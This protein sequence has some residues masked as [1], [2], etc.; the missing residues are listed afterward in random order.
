MKP[1]SIILDLLR[2]Y[3]SRGT[4]VQKIMAT[5]SM[6]GF[7][8]NLMRVSLSRLATKGTIENF[9]RGLYRLTDS[10]DH[11]NDFIE[12]WRLGEAKRRDWNGHWI[13]V[14]HQG[15]SWALKANG[16]IQLE[17]TLWVRPDNLARSTEQ[18]Q[19][20]LVNLGAKQECIVA[21]GANL[22]EKRVENALANF[23]IET[24]NQNYTKASEKLADSLNRLNTM[25]VDAAQR[26]SFHLGGNAIQILALDPLLPDE[27]MPAIDRHELWKTTLIY[28]KVGR[29]IWRDRTGEQLTTLPRAQ[30]NTR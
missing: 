6:F 26:E 7:S 16:F 27:V 4:A 10:T 8:E 22:T 17:G 14:E 11:L 19:A 9:Q 20:L 29:E 23:N 1:A 28:D 13:L 2:T 30:V 12:E 24:L 3:S 21:T 18:L 25:P 15:D 5:G